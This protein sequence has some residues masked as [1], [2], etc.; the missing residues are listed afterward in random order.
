M[1]HPKNIFVG[2]RKALCLLLKSLI[3]LTFMRFCAKLGFSQEADRQEQGTHGS[4]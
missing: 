2:P 4:L 1:G 3:S